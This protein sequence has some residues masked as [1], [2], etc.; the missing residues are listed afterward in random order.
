LLVADV[1][2]RRA[3][4]TL[5]A[6]W[7]LRVPLA[8]LL[9]VAIPSAITIPGDLGEALKGIFGFGGQFSA[10]QVS[11]AVGEFLVVVAFVSVARG[12]YALNGA[13]KLFALLIVVLFLYAL[14]SIGRAVLIWEAYYPAGPFPILCVTAA[15]LAMTVVVTI[16]VLQYAWQL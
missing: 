13:S 3:H 15:K 14:T 16:T 7:E 2:A 10:R 11:L 6:P 8:L 9:V 12:V 4:H 5:G 1:R